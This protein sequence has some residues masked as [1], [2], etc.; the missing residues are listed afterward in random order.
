VSGGDARAA[1]EQARRTGA[2][3][4]WNAGC[5]AFAEAVLAGRARNAE[6]AA[7]CADDGRAQ[8]AGFARWWTYLAW[9]L[10][11][12][13]ALRDGWGEP[14]SWMREA[15]DGF[16]KTG[17]D[18][19]ASACRGILRRT[20]EP[21]PRSGRGAATVPAALRR[22]GV[23]SREMDVFLLVARGQSNSEIAAN[24]YISPKTVDTHVASLIA[25]TGKACRRE[26][27]A[28]AARFEVS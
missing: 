12:P 14:A 6:R 25:K 2:D 11:A 18:Q 1:I 3:T 20:G 21:V 13:L 15:I 7:A 16:E 9:R 28:H 27:V 23:T 17:H 19:L 10:V 4:S 26:L 8:F 5:L 24:L 22:L